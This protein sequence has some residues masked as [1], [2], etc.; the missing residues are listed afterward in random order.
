MEN[1]VLGLHPTCKNRMSV[2]TSLPFNYGILANFGFRTKLKTLSFFKC[3]A[4]VAVFT[5]IYV[6]R[7][8]Y[9]SFFHVF[10]VSV[11]VCFSRMSFGLSATDGSA[12]SCR[13]NHR[14]LRTVPHR[15]VEPSAA[16]CF[17]AGIGRAA[18]PRG[19]NW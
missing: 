8:P 4:K 17:K 10:S 9:F 18:F 16:G 19:K 3:G 15:A 6:H 12:A 5:D 1:A 13:R 14:F 11:Q 2:I 7:T